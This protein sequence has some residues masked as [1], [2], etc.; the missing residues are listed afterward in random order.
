MTPWSS[1][2]PISCVQLWRDAVGPS[3][4]A[5][6]AFQSPAKTL[7]PHTNPRPTPAWALAGMKWAGSS[8]LATPRSHRGEGERG[9]QPAPSHPLSRQPSR[10]RKP[11]ATCSWPGSPPLPPRGVLPSSHVTDMDSG[12]G[13]T[14]PK[15][16]RRGWMTDQDPQGPPPC[17]P[18]DS[19]GMGSSSRPSPGVSITRQRQ[20]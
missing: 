16:H 14:C 3:G 7:R 11:P 2:S 9:P 20:A 17:S 10:P 4:A 8:R 1:S 13:A 12:R 19:A 5:P 15:T 6:W 18:A